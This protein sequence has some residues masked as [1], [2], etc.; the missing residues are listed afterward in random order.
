MVGEQ[1][2]NF[3][4]KMSLL[5]GG[6]SSS[7]T[8]IT[9]CDIPKLSA[10]PGKPAG[11]GLEC[12]WLKWDFSFCH[13]LLTSATFPPGLLPKI[14]LIYFP[15][16]CSQNSSQKC[17]WIISPECQGWER[18]AEETRSSSAS[19]PG[20]VQ[21][22]QAQDNWGKSQRVWGLC[23][24]VQWG[25]GRADQTLWT[26]LSHRPGQWSVLQQQEGTSAER[27]LVK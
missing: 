26:P 27:E 20:L 12:V 17:P 23:V 21:T 25:L 13:L 6:G 7:S 5:R 11:L 15:Q 16:G 10:R 1:K 3:H 4:P 24:C 8:A 2:G 22:L 9:D 14:P 18:G 19:V